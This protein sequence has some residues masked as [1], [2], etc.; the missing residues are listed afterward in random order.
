[1]SEKNCVSELLPEYTSDVLFY[2]SGTKIDRNEDA[3]TEARGIKTYVRHPNILCKAQCQGK[4]TDKGKDA[5]KC[6]VCRRVQ[7]VV[8]DKFAVDDPDVVDSLSNIIKTREAEIKHHCA[9]KAARISEKERELANLD[10]QIAA[11]D[12]G[13]KNSIKQIKDQL[14]V[15]DSLKSDLKDTSEKSLTSDIQDDTKSRDFTSLTSWIFFIRSH[16]LRIDS[17]IFFIFLFIILLLLIAA[18][19]FVG[20]GLY[21]KYLLK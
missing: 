21:D 5:A 3:T 14:Y 19:L 7:Q 17:R 20:K 8:Q 6:Q 16:F 11:K 12:R 13:V 10:A 18:N 4:D 1:M 9:L 2:R 15:M